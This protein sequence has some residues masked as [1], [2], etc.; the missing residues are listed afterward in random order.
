M[1]IV[2]LLTVADRI[3]LRARQHVMCEGLKQYGGYT[4]EAVLLSLQTRRALSL[5]KAMELDGTTVK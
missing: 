5:V 2:M 4:Q 1:L 3:N